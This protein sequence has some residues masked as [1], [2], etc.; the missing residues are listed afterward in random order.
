MLGL[1]TAALVS[2]PGS[3]SQRPADTSVAAGQQDNPAA[4]VPTSPAGTP[5][6]PA[7]TAT[8]LPG[9]IRQL[10]PAAPSDRG[11][12]PHVGAEQE[13]PSPDSVPAALPSCVQAAVTGHQGQQPLLV[14]HGSF[15]SAPVDVYVFRVS[16]D[17]TELDVFLLTPGCATATP[18]GTADVLLH[19][20][21]PAS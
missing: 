9:Q 11:T 7:F 6:G 14:T 15:R 2:G 16:G 17:P 4:A 13:G 12:L 19:E 21:V 5:Y 20:E 3:G 10:L 8:G 1:G 18:A